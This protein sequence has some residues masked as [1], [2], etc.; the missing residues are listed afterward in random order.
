MAIFVYRVRMKYFMPLLSLGFGIG[1]VRNK[2]STFV[3]APYRCLT[4]RDV[5]TNIGVTI[6]RMSI[7][8]A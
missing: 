7:M 1:G 8:S 3:F 5:S 2:R 4:A 6:L